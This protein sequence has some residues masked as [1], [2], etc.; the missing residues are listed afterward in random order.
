MFV[1]A[2]FNVNQRQRLWVLMDTHTC[3]PLLYPLQYLV[4]HLAL[5]TAELPNP[6]H[7]KR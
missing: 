1:L 5:R 6:L 2:Q 7:F 4:Y 3:L